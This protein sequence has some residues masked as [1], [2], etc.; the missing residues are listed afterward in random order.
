[1]QTV[2]VFNLTSLNLTAETCN[3]EYEEESDVDLVAGQAAP[4]RLSFL[5]EMA[6]ASGEHV[7]FRLPNFTGAAFEL[8]P[9]GLDTNANLSSVAWRPAGARPPGCEDGACVVVLLNQ[10]VAARESVCVWI[11]A[12]AG[13]TIPAVGLRRDQPSVTAQTDALTGKILLLLLYYARA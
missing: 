12:S 3:G 10:S 13:L 9:P 11:P 5:S 4:L 2:G 7:A 1:M 6:L 8:L